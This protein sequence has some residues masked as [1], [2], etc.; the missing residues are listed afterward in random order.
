[1]ATTANSDD[2]LAVNPVAY[3]TNWIEAALDVLGDCE[4]DRND[5]L[6]S[7]TFGTSGTEVRLELWESEVPGPQEEPVL[8]LTFDVLTKA[9][10]TA[11]W[12]GERWQRTEHDCNGIYA[13]ERL[14][15]AVHIF[16]R[17][18]RKC[19]TP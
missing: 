3:L 17:P 4:V 14:V 7:H 9:L 12:D 19:L 2:L 8:S 1:M 18:V 15:D 16:Q 11:H 6:G 10:T 13:G 5:S